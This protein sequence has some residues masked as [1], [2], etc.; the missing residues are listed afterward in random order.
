MKQKNVKYVG[1][2][3]GQKYYVE[4]PMSHKLVKNR[5]QLP[6]YYVSDHHKPIVDRETFNKAQEIYNS[7]STKI[8]NGEVYCEKYSLKY[9][10]SSTVYCQCCQQTYVRRSTNY[11][12]KVRVTHNHVYWACSGKKLNVC[13]DSVSIREEELESLFVS[14]FNKF[15]KETK[16]DDLINKIKKVIC[17]E[18]DNT[19]IKKMISK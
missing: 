14:L 17:K 4:N 7:R 6:K 19:Q 5:G 2:I 16:N 13:T 18:S 15:I 9:P 11:T 8:K 10:F 1:D 3:C 12:N